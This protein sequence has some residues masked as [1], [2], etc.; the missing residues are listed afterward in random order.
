[1]PTNPSVATLPWD[2][3]VSMEEVE[4]NTIGVKS[5]SPGPNSMPVSHQAYFQGSFSAMPR[6]ELL[7]TSLATSGGSYDPQCGSK[8]L[9]IH[10]TRVLERT[11]SSASSI[12]VVDLA[13]ALTCDVEATWAKGHWRTLPSL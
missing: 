5:T 9:V 4:Q 12:S 3:T 11:A 13:N 8:S 1:M 7:S 10:R 6:T 2:T